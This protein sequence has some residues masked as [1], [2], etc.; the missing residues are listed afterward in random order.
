MN[1]EVNIDSFIFPD[2]LLTINGALYGYVSEVVR[3]NLFGSWME[4]FFIKDGIDY[5]KLK[6]AYQKFKDDVFLLTEKKIKIYDLTNNL[7]FDGEKMYAIDTCSY[8]Y[9][10]ESDLLIH[11]MQ[12]LEDAMDVLFVLLSVYSERIVL[13]REKTGLSILQH[14]DYIE[15]T[16]KKCVFPQNKQKALELFIPN[17]KVIF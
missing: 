11:N 5:E 9:S 15:K 6:S 12:A 17:K 1:D 14:I 10:K 4:T 7:L 2:S 16:L 3:D 13:D 8:R